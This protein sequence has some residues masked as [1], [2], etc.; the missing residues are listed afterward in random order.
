M[1]VAYADR[2][3]LVGSTAGKARHVESGLRTPEHPAED[4][5]IPQTRLVTGAHAKFF[6]LHDHLNCRKQ[7]TQFQ[8]TS[9]AVARNPEILETK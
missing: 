9:T 2:C 7:V 4:D 5:L 3:G 8:I 1:S 6:R